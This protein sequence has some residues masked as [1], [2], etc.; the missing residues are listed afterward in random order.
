MELM[1][2]MKTFQWCDFLHLW[3]TTP[4]NVMNLFPRAFFRRK[5]FCIFRKKLFY[6]HREIFQ[7]CRDAAYGLIH[8]M[9]TVCCNSKKP[10][11]SSGSLHVGSII[12][13]LKCISHFFLTSLPKFF[14]FRLRN[15]KRWFL[16]QFQTLCRCCR[17][18]AVSFVCANVFAFG[19]DFDVSQ[20]FLFD[21]A[22]KLNG[23]K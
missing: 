20:M 9:K 16:F 15:L 10:V 6:F 4:R 18:K 7:L 23:K 5:N 21:I 22:F 3:N 12:P 2:F 13:Q 19:P 1:E 17:C 11:L 14:F 8:H